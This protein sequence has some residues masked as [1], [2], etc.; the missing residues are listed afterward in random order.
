MEIINKIKRR[1]PATKQK[2][3]YVEA[4]ID[5]ATQ[6]IEKLSKLM[7]GMNEQLNGMSKQ[8]Q[9][10]NEYMHSL[11]K[12]QTDTLNPIS[13]NVKR[14]RDEVHNSFV[15][16]KD[17][18]NE[19]HNSFQT[20]QGIREE[21]HNSFTVV[22]EVRKEV[23]DNNKYLKNQAGKQLQLDETIQIVKNVVEHG[24]QGI[25]KR[26]HTP[27][28]I[29]SLT[30]YPK[31]IATTAVALERVFAQT[32]K[33]DRIILWLSEENF[34][35][36]EAEL[37][38]QLLDLKQ[39]GLEIEWCQGDIRSY[40][41]LIPAL[42]KYPEDIIITLDDDLFYE[43]DLVE[44]LYNSYKKHP[45]AISAM[46]THKI[47]FEENGEVSLYSQWTKDCSEY[48][49]EP[50]RE[51]FATTGAGTLFP[52]KV[53]DSRVTEENAFFTLAPTADDMWVK[54]MAELAETPVVLVRENKPLR[55]IDG[56]Q[57]ETLWG[58]N[59]SQNDI[60]LKNIMEKYQITMGANQ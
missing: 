42:E 6:E 50:R 43:L 16:V 25:S 19:V 35:A 31:R 51:L 24:N 56:T 58:T 57:E 12:K 37:P 13:D 18:R 10:I 15:A 4:K 33:P 2:V 27:Q 28:L 21:L 17:V 7:C 41:K 39:R 46:R 48:I 23:H 55:Y 36:K 44:K 3:E 11:E 22:Q 47:N 34:P 1:L 32:L 29:V 60:Q 49:G 53:L 54:C 30:S 26:A 52:P 45:T 8:L 14:I 9:S 20:V 5:N 40:K 59:M 38:L